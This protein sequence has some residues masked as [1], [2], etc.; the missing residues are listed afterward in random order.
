MFSIIPTIFQST[1]PTFACFQLY[2]SRLHRANKSE[3]KWSRKKKMNLP[4]YCFTSRAAH[5]EMIR[6]LIEAMVNFR[7]LKHVGGERLDVLRP[8]ELLSPAAKRVS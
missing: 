3:R 8:T 7:P 5:I 6:S 1:S 4:L 2:W